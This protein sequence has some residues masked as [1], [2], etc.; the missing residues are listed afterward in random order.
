MKEITL[1]HYVMKDIN[2]SPWEKTWENLMK[3]GSRIAP[4]IAPMGYTI[5]LRKVIMEDLT[6]DN[7]MSANMVTIECADANVPETPIEN[8]IMLQLDFSEC[9]EC[10]TPSGQEFPCRTFETFTGEKCQVLPEEFFME[11]VLRV[12]FKAQHTEGAHCHCGEDC[13]SCASGCGDEEIG[14]RHD[15]GRK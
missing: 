13:S 9:S 2:A 5:K 6:E 7:L 11:A 8:I 4:K 1:A 3:F 12:A 15:C 14:K 10:K